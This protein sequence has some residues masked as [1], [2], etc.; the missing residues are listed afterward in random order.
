MALKGFKILITG[1]AGNLG[2]TLAKSLV[3]ENELWGLDRYPF[4]GQ[5]DYWNSVGLRTVAADFASDD[6]K[7]IL[8]DDFDYVVHCAANMAPVDSEDGMRDNAE[9]TGLLM[10]HCRKAKAFLHVSTVGV[11]TIKDEPEPLYNEDDMLGGG[12]MGHYTGT[13]L[14]AEGAARA[15]C[16]VLNL[17]T[18]IC[19]MAVQY[20]ETGVG[21][22]MG[23]ILR[24]LLEGQ[25][26]PLR[27]GTRKAAL[28][29]NDDIARFLEPC[30]KAATVPATI[31]NWAGDEN[32]SVVEATE[33]LAA[34]A[35][36]KARFV[37]CS[38]DEGFPC[39]PLD[40]TR[41][42]SITGPGQVPW[43][44]GL[45]KLYEALSPG[46]RASIGG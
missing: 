46:I 4:D 7:P 11:Y 5:Q 10:S 23:I 35:G 9:G 41:R 28:I 24:M 27:R 43:R 15:M 16:R 42:Q 19:R 38:D 2:G 22:M 26:I 20:G 12:S 37:D 25:P 14:A 3:K 21:G 30:L 17:P 29:A 31:V 45:T 13:K 34:L 36:V 33:H 6:L 40:P 44:D 18:I 39:Y 32:V 8:P 1:P